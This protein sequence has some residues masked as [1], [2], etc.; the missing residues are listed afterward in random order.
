MSVNASCLMLNNAKR[1]FRICLAFFKDV[2]VVY[3]RLAIVINISLAIS[4]LFS[5]HRMHCSIDQSTWVTYGAFCKNWTSPRRV[6]KIYARTGSNFAD[7]MMATTRIANNT[8]FSN[9]NAYK[10][11]DQRGKDDVKEFSRCYAISDMWVT[12]SVIFW[13]RASPP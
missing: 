12:E 3:A 11:C 8:M 10:T 9:I 4:G 5:N 7:N 6:A 13:T 2:C 1:W